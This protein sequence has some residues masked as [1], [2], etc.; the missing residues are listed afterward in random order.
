MTEEAVFSK[1][2]AG[3]EELANRSGRLT[4]RQRRILIFVDGKNTLADLRSLVSAD[5]LTHTLGMLEEEGLISLT[6][7]RGESGAIVS[8]EGPL[9]SIT[10][11]LP[12]PPEH[13]PK[14]HDMAR[15]F[16]VNTLKT[17]CG[18]YSHYNLQADIF[19]SKDLQGLRTY[20]D[21]WCHALQESRDGRRRFEELRSQLLKVI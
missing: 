21:L 6:G 1:T 12:L 10:A 8:T 3:R 13:D 15:H 14:R 19:N 20:F 18:G 5:D 9:P 2:E 17:F 16:M 11:F 7:V 4:P